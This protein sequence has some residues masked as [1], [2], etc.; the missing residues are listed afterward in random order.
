MEKMR[1]YVAES[2]KRAV[3]SIATK[4]A[5]ANCFG[6]MY[7]PKKPERLAGKTK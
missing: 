1:V 4:K 6:F 2:V 7:E 3:E 5:N